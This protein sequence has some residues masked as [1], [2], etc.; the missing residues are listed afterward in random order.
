MRSTAIDRR[1][2]L[3]GAGA[4]MA[5]GL[6]ARAAERLAR[7]DMLFLAPCRRADGSFGVL[8]LT[9]RGETIRDIDLPARGHDSAV[10]AARGRAVAFA[11]RP[12]TFAVAFDAAGMRPTKII[13]APADRHFYGHGAFSAD[14]ELLYA[15]ENDFAVPRGVIGIYDASADFRRIGEFSTHGVGPHEALLLPDGRTLAVANGG[16]ETNPTFGREKLNLPTMAP[17]LAL[18]DISTGECLAVHALPK[19]KHMLSIRHM[20][21]GA[22][23]SLWFGTQWEGDPL[24][25]P[26]LVGRLG[27]GGGLVL[28][29]IGGA[30]LTEMRAYVGAMAASRDGSMIAASAPRGGFLCYWSATTGRFLGRTAIEDSSGIT[31]I[32]KSLFLAS[33]G[34]GKIVEASPGEV[35]DLGTA[36]VAFDNHLRLAG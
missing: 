21:V 14:G 26:P 30:E 9:E 27:R 22:D 11:R 33:N 1:A 5:L 20:A 15:T 3:A 25:T 35:R 4:A 8:V 16:I 32:G 31:G 7:S 2:F 23:G 13:T 18:L 28:A 34:A 36:P 19:D 10:D 12:G 6:P 29:D 17:S 24:E